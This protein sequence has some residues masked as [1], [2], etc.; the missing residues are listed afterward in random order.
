MYEAVSFPWYYVLGG[1]V[2]MFCALM[3]S[4]VVLFNFF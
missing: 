1:A 2:L 3:V 4:V